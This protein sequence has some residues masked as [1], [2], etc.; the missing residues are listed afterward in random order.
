TGGEIM[1][2]LRGRPKRT[3]AWAAML[4]GVPAV[5]FVV[6]APNRA[7]GPCQIRSKNRIEVRARVPGILEEVHH[8]EGD[9]LLRDELIARLEIPDLTSRIDQKVAEMDEVRA[10]FEQLAVGAGEVELD[11]QQKRVERAREWVTDAKADLERARLA[12][13]DELKQLDDQLAQQCTER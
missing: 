10:K 13:K 2:M 9:T 11:E 1:N 12:I 7:G 8:E 3:A 6:P 4:L 5:L